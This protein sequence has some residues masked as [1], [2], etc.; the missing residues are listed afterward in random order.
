L[1]ALAP[2]GFPRRQ[3]FFENRNIFSG[4]HL[5]DLPIGVK[6]NHGKRM[7][8]ADTTNGK[9]VTMSTVTSPAVLSPAA[10]DLRVSLFTSAIT[11]GIDEGRRSLTEI[12]WWIHSQAG[13]LITGVRAS[14]LA[15]VETVRQMAVD[16]LTALPETIPAGWPGNS[17]I[18]A[19]Q[20]TSPDH[21]V[22]E[23]PPRRR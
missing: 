15:D 18:A 8:Q 2:R 4:S 3:P 17:A 10:S 6:Y 23:M 16:R 21:I 22:P 1:N 19:V 9:P 11:A 20:T 12:T 5:T 14:V 13:A 7:T